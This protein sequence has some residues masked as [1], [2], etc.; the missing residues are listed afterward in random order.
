MY[1]FQVLGL[2]VNAEV[3]C[4]AMGL[5]CKS[6]HTMA[7]LA[8]LHLQSMIWLAILWRKIIFVDRGLGMSESPV[9]AVG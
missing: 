1:V 9:R 6:Y 4:A 3:A 7:W 2:G 8:V 5:I